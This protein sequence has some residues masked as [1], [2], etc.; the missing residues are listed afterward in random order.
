LD[1]IKNSEVTKR[2]IKW[3]HSRKII[4]KLIETLDKKMISMC[5]LKGSILF[6]H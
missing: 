4:V 1:S 6:T 2:R 3:Q 5:N